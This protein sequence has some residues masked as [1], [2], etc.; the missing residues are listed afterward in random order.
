MGAK[1][2]APTVS[3]LGCEIHALS[4]SETVVEVDR[5]IRARRPVQHCVINASKAVLLQKDAR[6][7][8]ILSTCALVNA[9]GQSIVWAARLLGKPLP[10]RVAGIDLFISLLTLAEDRGYGVY[11]LG[12]TDD[13]VRVVVERA[14]R[15]H[16]LL[17]IG[18][19]HH[20]YLR[21]AD[22]EAVIGE[23]NECKPEILFVGM[24]S[25]RKEYWLAE[26][27]ERLGVPFCMGV[28]G[29]FDV[30]AGSKNRAP[31]WM[32]RAG[33]EWFHRF[34]SEPR[35]MWRR[36]LFGNAAF[37]NLVYR[38]YREERRS[39]DSKFSREVQ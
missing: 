19:W 18:G 5:L 13:V 2:A 26:N 7:R 8:Q 20:G 24:P 4:L 27:L 28:G 15:E 31:L 21:A 10:E 39:G 34:C 3:L 36:Y 35:R 22:T 14:R 23:M 11:F 32:Q 29:S 16:P 12:A 6:L 1:A 37:V 9:D 33:L 30:Y 17:C 38:A 25:P